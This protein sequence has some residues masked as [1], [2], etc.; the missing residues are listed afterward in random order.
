MRDTDPAALSVSFSSLPSNFFTASLT[1]L[2][3]I[4]VLDGEVRIEF[5]KEWWLDDSIFPPFLAPCWFAERRKTGER[6]AKNIC[7]PYFAGTKW[8]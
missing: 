6:K 8:L 5:W 1:W 7:V 4:G 2:V 3:L